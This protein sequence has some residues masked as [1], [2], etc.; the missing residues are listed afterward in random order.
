MLL[1]VDDDLFQD[2]ESTLGKVC[3]SYDRLECKLTISRQ[4]KKWMADLANEVGVSTSLRFVPGRAHEQNR[5]LLARIMGDLKPSEGA[6][7]GLPREPFQRFEH[8]LSMVTTSIALAPA[9]N[10]AESS[11]QCITP[12]GIR[13]IP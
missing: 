11:I 5:L 10:G 1:L 9:A 7:E 3:A 2:S 12:N 4:F 8:I 6:Q 13:I